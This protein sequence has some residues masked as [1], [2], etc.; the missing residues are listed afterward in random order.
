MAYKIALTAGH[1][2]GTPGKRCL[3][4]LDPKE[5]REW[6]LN[7]RI[8]EKIE[9]GLR[10]YTGYDLLRTDDEVG[11]VDISLQQRTDMANRFG[12]DF[13]LSIHHNAGVNG[14]SGGGIVAYVY[15]NPQAEA[16]AWQKDLYNALIA[17]TG[18]K[19]NRSQPLGK[20]NLHEVRETNM[21]AVLL[22]LGFMDSTTDVPIILTEDY[23]QKCADAIVGVI[24]KRA[25]LEKKPTKK[26]ETP[27]KRYNTLAEVPPFAQPTV[28]KLIDAKALNGSG[29]VKDANG[30][31]ADLDLSYD[32][33]RLLVI[34]D[35]MGLY[36]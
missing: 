26:E 34:H 21:P 10:A 4:S 13:Y 17:A 9:R 31:P 16:V 30:D 15:T 32:M 2:M 27:V 8:V 22:E 25:G 6:E 7:A 1:Y 11:T 18:L 36:N 23:A 35:R 28:R 29:K 14:G 20:A 12:A 33:I 3:K 19:G 24:V 5:T